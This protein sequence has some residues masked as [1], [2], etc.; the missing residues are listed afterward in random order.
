MYEIKTAK[1]NTLVRCA[2]AAVASIDIGVG[3]GVGAGWRHARPGEYMRRRQGAVGRSVQDRWPCH[4][5]AFGRSRA[6]VQPPPRPPAAAP[7]P[8]RRRRRRRC[9]C[10]RMEKSRGQGSPRPP[11]RPCRRRRPNRNLQPARPRRAASW[12]ALS[13]ERSSGGAVVGGATDGGG[14][15]HGRTPGL[16]RGRPAGGSCL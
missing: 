7:P 8:P 13:V 1:V 10:N 9:R 11:L 12:G 6:V 14:W 16:Q 15:G 2:A 4:G 3:A 5:G